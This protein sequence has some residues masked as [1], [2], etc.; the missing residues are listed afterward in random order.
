LKNTALLIKGSS[1]ARELGITALSI[2]L[3]F[4][5]SAFIIWAAGFSVSAVFR[6]PCLSTCGRV[7]SEGSS[8]SA[9]P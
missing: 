4:G 3:A 5:I 1:L 9:R 2:I 8:P 7:R 6:A